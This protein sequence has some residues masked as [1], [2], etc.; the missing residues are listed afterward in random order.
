MCTFVNTVSLSGNLTGMP[1]FDT[2]KATF[3][4]AHN[5][6]PSRKPL[7]RN[8][9]VYYEDIPRENL[10]FLTKGRRVV[11]TGRLSDLPC[12]NPNIQIERIVAKEIIDDPYI[13]E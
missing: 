12:R 11:V 8:I 2:T 10:S 6:G 5:Q 4:I 1:V 13:S 9:I 7:V 3:K